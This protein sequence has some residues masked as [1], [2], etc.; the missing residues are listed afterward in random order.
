MLDNIE[1]KELNGIQYIKKDDTWY[2]FVPGRNVLHHIEK[3]GT[4]E[5]AV[6]AWDTRGRGRK[7]DEKSD[8]SSRSSVDVKSMEKEKWTKSEFENGEEPPTE[9]NPVEIDSYPYWYGDSDQT[10]QEAS[11]KTYFHNGV[12]IYEPLDSEL[13]DMNK[14][15]NETIKSAI[16][17]VPPELRE[18]LEAVQINPYQ[19][20]DQSAR[21]QAEGNTIIIFGDQEKEDAK[22]T[23]KELP[24]I[25]NHEAAHLY[26][27]AND[28]ISKTEEY[29]MAIKSDG[30][31]VTSYSEQ[32]MK[33]SGIGGRVGEAEDFAEA[34]ASYVQDKKSFAEKFPARSSII[35]KIFK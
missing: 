1:F 24:Y 18:H 12:Q 34:V 23:S 3:Y 10:E 25:L 7:E 14:I 31:H 6:A 9:D 20:Q 33:M 11:A 26:D 32:S 2:Y 19:E 8:D 30:N 16:D 29:K 28:R 15:S 35:G 17:Q 5:G 22:E 21:A 4:S 13:R 27:Q